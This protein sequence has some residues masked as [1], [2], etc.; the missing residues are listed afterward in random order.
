MRVLVVGLAQTGDA[1][2]RWAR[3]RGD[4]VTVVEERP[5]SGPIAVERHDRAHALGATVIERP[6]DPASVLDH[7]DLVVPSPGVAP[8]HPLLVEARARGL[9]VRSEIDVAAGAAAR[10]REPTAP[11]GDHRDERQDDGDDS[12]GSHGACRRSTRGRGRQR[13]LSAPRCDRRRCRGGGGRG[14]VVPARV[15]NRG[16]PSG[17]RG[18]AERGRGP[19]RLARLGGCLRA[20]QG[21]RLR[22]P[23][24]RGCA[25]GER[26]RSARVGA[27]RGRAEPRRADHRR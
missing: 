6:V 26:T 16:V 18:P 11:G 4:D 7:T 27:G 14:V 21:A 20:R 24:S 9:A 12:R 2:V 8:R 15:H 19:P 23:A 1:V 3:G 10:A 22:S 5:S 17:G 13:R 25:R